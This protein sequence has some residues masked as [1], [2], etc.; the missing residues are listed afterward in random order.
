[1]GFYALHSCSISS[2]PF[3]AASL[4]PSCPPFTAQLYFFHSTSATF[5]GTLKKQTHPCMPSCVVPSAPPIDVLKDERPGQQVPSSVPAHAQRRP[6]P[7]TP[8]GFRSLRVRAGLCGLR[9]DKLCST[10]FSWIS[11]LWAV[12]ENCALVKKSWM[13]ASQKEELWLAL[14]PDCLVWRVSQSL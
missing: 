10:T 1:M 4:R 14:L 6:T 2:P 11:I 3:P 9:T 7:L 5:P 13:Q 12:I 8:L